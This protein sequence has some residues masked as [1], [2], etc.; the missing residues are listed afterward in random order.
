VPQ[1]RCECRRE[2]SPVTVP[3]YMRIS[4]RA[5]E[6]QIV[7]VEQT[8]TRDA[9]VIVGPDAHPTLD[10]RHP[11]I[12]LRVLMRVLSPTQHPT[13]IAVPCIDDASHPRPADQRAGTAPLSPGSAPSP[14][15]Q[16]RL[17]R[18]HGMSLDDAAGT[19]T[20]AA[21]GTLTL[22]YDRRVETRNAPRVH[23]CIDM[24]DRGCRPPIH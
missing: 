12:V 4:P 19:R 18:Q 11:P 7:T 14:L 20:G 3:L 17:I 21:R 16:P 24:P 15:S 6:A 22:S 2:R 13:P 5:Q 1:T 10:P 8:C 23:T 9:H